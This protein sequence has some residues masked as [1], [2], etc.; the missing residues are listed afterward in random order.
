M[1]QPQSQ[2]G[3]YLDVAHQGQ[4]QRWR[5]LAGIYLN[6]T[7][8][9]G[10]SL[11]LFQVAMMSGI[12]RQDQDRI[13]IVEPLHNYILA[14]LMFG[15]WG[16]GLWGVMRWIHRRDWRTLISADGQIDRLRIAQGFGVWMAL[17]GGPTLLAYGLDPQI[18]SVTIDWGRWLPFAMLALIM[19]PV[20]TTVE[21]LFFRGY[22]LQGLGLI[23]RRTGVLCGISAVIFALPHLNNPEV[24]HGFWPLCLYYFAFGWIHAWVTLRDG[25]LELAIGLHAANNL[26]AALFVT[27]E[28]AVIETPALFASA[29]FHPWAVLWGFLIRSLG[30]C[31][32]FFAPQIKLKLKKDP[33]AS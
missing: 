15:F 29:G 1:A 16:L 9:F 23:T 25:R 11:L 8:W 26:F 17:I 2:G 18:L 3:I 31:Y 12:A 32:L 30:F 13:V 22:L 5:Y 20:Q 19:T 14:N 27:Y 33:Q 10:L 4:P 24:A 21:E 6:F 7:I 28:D